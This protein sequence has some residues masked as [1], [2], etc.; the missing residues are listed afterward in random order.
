MLYYIAI[1]ITIISNV[2]Y[3]LLQKAIPK[4][5]NL[6]ISLI[7][8]YITSIVICITIFL[9]NSNWAN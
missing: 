4:E 5:T 3:Q 6:F 8:T 2:F 9:F 1:A 7:V